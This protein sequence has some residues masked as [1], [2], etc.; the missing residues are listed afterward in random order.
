M[1][2]FF[3]TRKL[4]PVATTPRSVPRANVTLISGADAD[5]TAADGDLNGAF[6]GCLLG[7][8]GGGGQSWGELFAATAARMSRVCSYQHPQ[9]IRV[10]GAA[11]DGE[12]VFAL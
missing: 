1:A 5:E 4:G 9:W 7:E 2:P 10:S 12:R 3:V 6:T 11:L 8:A